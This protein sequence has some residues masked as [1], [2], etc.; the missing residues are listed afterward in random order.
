MGPPTLLRKRLLAWY[1]E[2]ARKNLPWRKTRNPY[3]IWVSETMLQQ[4]QVATVIPYYGRFL[5]KFP[6]LK[7]LAEAPLSRV[8]DGWSGLGYYSRAKNLH[9]AARQ[10]LKEH[11][12]RVPD[13]V[14]DLLRLP[15]VGR[16]TAGA[17][18][19]IAYDRPAPVL[20][21]NVTRVLTRI[22]GIR[23][24]P[25]GP[26]VQSRLWETAQRL[27]PD[28]SAGTFNQALMELGAL[29][30]LPRNPRCSAC[31]ASYD[32]VARENGWQQEI[33]LRGDPPTRKRIRYLCGILERNG[34]VLLARRPFSGLLPGLWEFPG[35]EK[36]PGES[37]SE[38]LSRSLKERLGIR[39]EPQAFRS[40]VEQTLTHRE[41]QIRAFDCRFNGGSIH[42]R[43]YLETHWAPRKDLEKMALT[44]GMRKL[45]QQL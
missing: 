42:P 18:A 43:W 33:P 27:V 34:S 8:L 39:V 41:L 25:K 19:S 7:A 31:P 9:A 6:T 40:S 45:V 13:Q 2:K 12:G 10:I 11:R 1:R 44:A 16:Y 32:C 35:G 22:L 3:R 23:Q 14:Q 24:D 38:G 4:T 5:K 17:V 26:A 30:C 15:G 20:D 28:E 36:Q 37:D 21:G 29:V